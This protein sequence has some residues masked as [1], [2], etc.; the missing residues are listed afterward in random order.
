MEQC[1]VLNP[2]NQLLIIHWRQ[3]SRATEALPRYDNAVKPRDLTGKVIVI[4]GASSGIGAATAI[5]CAKAGMHVTLAARREDKLARVAQQVEATGARA[6]A[7]KCDVT[8]SADLKQ[9]FDQS[10][11]T[12]GRLDVIFA[13][14]GYGLVGTVLG[15][16]EAQ[17]R[18]IFEV[19]YFATL[20]TVRAGIEHL[21]RTDPGL[22]HVLICSS[23]ASEVGLPN[24]GAYGATK[25]AQDSIAAALRGEVAREG[26]AVTSIHPVGTATE[27]FDT[28]AARSGTQGRN[29]NTPKKLIQAPEHVAATI[30]KAIRRPQPEVWPMPLARWGLALFTAM[31]RLS[32]AVMRRH[33]RKLV[34]FH[35]KP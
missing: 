21:R 34:P 4:T 7:V 9:L 20:G 1:G 10:W 2:F 15:T 35:Q 8:V 14:A 12:F 17:H 32:A 18:D 6:L 19:N 27:F 23:A 16:T 3:Y 22:K 26:I 31:P 29:A 33:A 25:A 13:N 24:A 11:Q 28:A 30:V 5:A